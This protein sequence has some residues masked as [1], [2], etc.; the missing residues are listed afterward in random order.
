[1]RGSL[2]FVREATNRNMCSHTRACITKSCANKRENK[3]WL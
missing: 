3:A 2:K 1:M